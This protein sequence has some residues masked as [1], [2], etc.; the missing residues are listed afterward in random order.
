MN[1]FVS[2]GEISGD[3]HLSYLVEEIKKINLN[4]KFYGMCGKY[5]EKVGVNIVE[6]IDNISIM[7]FVDVI[8]KYKELKKRLNRFI[9]FID[10]NNIKNIILVDYGGFNLALLKKLKERE[11]STKKKY[12][13]F[14]YIPPK[15][16]VWGEK[17]IKKLN[18]ADFILSILPWEEEFYK[19]HNREIV[20]YGNPLVDKF[21]FNYNKNADKILLLPG[22]R[23]QEIVSL[24][25]E[26]LKIVK[27]NSEKKF[28]LKLANK[29][30]L[31]WIEI[32]KYD[33]LEI[34]IDVTLM[35][36]SRDIKF[37][38]AASGTV[39][40]ELALIGIPTIVG[41]KISILNEIIA[42]LLID[43]KY[44][45]LPNITLDKEIFPEL[46]QNKFNVKNIEK[47]IEYIE[48]NIE[49]ILDD[50][51][52]VREKLGKRDIVKKYAKFIIGKID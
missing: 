45:S 34:V 6:N 24:L 44:V 17:R 46:L 27:I 14:Y 47:S 32:P 2:A 13:V 19:K 37:A 8:F 51:K 26:M 30:S 11:K 23:K 52:S 1:F 42:K 15:L 36:V 48:N 35:D 39:T 31:D 3:I 9:N 16:W 41:Y 5:S 7:G 18:L 25:P 33:N 29:E 12:K 10:E 4:T 20:Y 21:K 28:I 49:N 22:S 40:L 50:L 43:Y 38:I